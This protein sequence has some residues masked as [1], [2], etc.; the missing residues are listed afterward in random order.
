MYV[1]RG[2]KSL[3]EV[4]KGATFKGLEKGKK[5]RSDFFC[6]KSLNEALNW[7]YCLNK[8]PTNQIPKDFV[9]PEEPMKLLFSVSKA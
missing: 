5:A 7:K 6:P 8:A 1:R 3:S 4:S 2:K 9:H